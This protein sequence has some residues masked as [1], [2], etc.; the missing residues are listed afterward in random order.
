MDDPGDRTIIGNN[1]PR[2]NYGINLSV[3]YFGFDFGI[4]FQGVGKMDW[5]PAA[6]NVLFYGPYARPYATLIPKDFHKKIWSEDNPD[7][8]LPRPRGYVGLGSNRELTV[9]SDRY[10]QD[11]SYCRLKNLTFGYTLPKFI[12]DKIGMGPVRFSFSGENLAYW[13]PFKKHTKYI[14]P[15]MAKTNSTNRIYPWQKSFMFGIDLTF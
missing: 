11:I 10:L 4:F 7:A 1:Q 12:T 3:Q 15:E 8:Y 6:N 2:Y 9:P 5:A 14:D 13:S